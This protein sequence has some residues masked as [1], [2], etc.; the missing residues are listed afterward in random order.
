MNILVLSKIYPAHDINIQDTKVVHYFAKEWKRMGYN[1]LV[2]H[3]F[4]IFPSPVYWITKLF[5]KKLAT[6]FGA[7]VPTVND[8]RIK[9]FEYEGID[10]V[11][12]PIRKNIPH[13]MFTRNAIKQHYKT[14][15]DILKKKNF[16]PDYV[17]GHWW[18]PQLQL[19]K[20]FKEE[21]GSINC[22]VVHNNVNR[23]RAN[24]YACYFEDIDVFG[25]RSKP[26]EREFVKKFGS[27]Y[28]TFHCAS[29]IPEKYIVGNDFRDFDN[30]ILRLCYVGTMIKRKYP[31]SILK[32]LETINQDVNR[33]IVKFVGDGAELR[34][35]KSRIAKKKWKNQITI[36]GAVPRDKVSEV[37][38][39]SDCFVMIS[40]DE[41]FGLVY[42][43]AM[44]CGCIP[45]ASRNEGMDGIIV[46]GENGFLCEA[47][48]YRE[49]SILLKKIYNLPDY[50]RRR[51]SNNAVKTASN[52][53]D[54]LAAKRYI[55]NVKNMCK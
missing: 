41:A 17:V 28:K 8:Y 34:N 42:L 4:V 21:Y 3:N 51:I 45:I 6:F 15:H 5:S 30:S 50:E 37:L 27:M 13:G 48:N 23:I 26:I 22:L 43:E 16:N 14:I 1:V 46:E 40:K 55:D 10:V 20:Y 33:Y 25:M 32:A 24:N 2:I 52:Y 18:N 44:G 39:N 9:E 11:R 29:G 47:G 53:T 12:V 36:Y 54:L 49:L 31:I 35:I 19:Y 38:T 7:V